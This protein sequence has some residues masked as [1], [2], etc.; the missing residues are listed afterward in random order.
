MAVPLLVLAGLSIVGGVLNLP[1]SGWQRLEHW[2]EPVFGD[3]LRDVDATTGTKALLLL[4]AVVAG[5]IGIALAA[6]AWLRARVDTA[7]LEPAVLRRGWGVDD[8]FAALIDG[9]G[10]LA[11]AWATYVVDLKVV[12]GAV[13]GLAAVV[14]A[15]GARLRRVQTG[16][17]RNYALGVALGTVL[18]LAF[19]VSRAGVS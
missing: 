13:N 4:S 6:A 2:L 12:D 5:L 10:R 19:M 14:R 9:P 15:G 11:A 7:R 18:L 3:R 17:V 16:F 1:F 8:A